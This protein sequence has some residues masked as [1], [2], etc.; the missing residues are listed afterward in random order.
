MER[1]CV[2]TGNGGTEDVGVEL[3]SLFRHRFIEDLIAQPHL[4][5]RGVL[6]IIAGQF[7]YQLTVFL[8]VL[9]EDLI[10]PAVHLGDL[11]QFFLF[12][13]IGYLSEGEHLLGLGVSVRLQQE[14]VLGVSDHKGV[15][16]DIA[17]QDGLIVRLGD[18]YAV[19][20]GTESHW[21]L[22]VALGE[23]LGIQGSRFRKGVHA[24]KLKDFLTGLF[25]FRQ[26]PGDAGHGAC[27]I[28]KSHTA[29]GFDDALL[30]QAFGLG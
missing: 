2:V 25:L 15:H 21:Q 5:D 9:A 10:D 20:A 30:E 18:E 3:T 16:M 27:G 6:I 7:L 19:D 13:V 12:T 29:D 14:L 24:Q 22:V 28:F 23:G 17:V 4:A 1:S 11:V 26:C 8:S